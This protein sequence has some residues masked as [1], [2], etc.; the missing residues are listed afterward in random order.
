MHAFPQ[1][2]TTSQPGCLFYPQALGLEAQQ[3][4]VEDMRQVLKAAPLF[5][6]V[7]PRTGQPLSVRMSNCGPL[8]WVADKAGYRYQPNHP[9]TGAPWPP[10]P[11][12]LSDLWE[13][14]APCAPQPEACL[15]N[16]YDPQARM[17]LHQDRDEESFEA[18][19][20]SVSLGDDGLFK[21]GGTQRGG[22]TQSIRLASGDVLVMGGPARLCFHGITRIYPGT[23]T[24]LDAPGRLNLTLRRVRA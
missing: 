16:W 23:S 6:P 13:Q 11:Q 10:M 3:S 7:M 22:K 9:V 17:G 1:A 20:L 18:P 8:G 14:L 5:Q 15:I 21:L 4:L 24:L 12:A 19:V 2:V